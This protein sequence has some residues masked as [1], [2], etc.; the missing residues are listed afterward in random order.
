MERVF[1]IFDTDNSGTISR[2]EFIESMKSIIIC[3]S[4]MD[5]L[6]LLFQIY[7]LDGNGCIS[8]EELRHVMMCCMEENG[9]SFSEEDLDL[10]TR[11]CL[12]MPLT[13]MK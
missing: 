11:T 3:R 12:K 7:D 5:K 13:I 4:P 6:R 1:R 8:V 10:L 9:L 2:Q